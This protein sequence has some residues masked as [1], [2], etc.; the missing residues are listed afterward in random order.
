MLVRE[1]G[2][3]VGTIGGGCTE[4]S[5]WALAREAIAADAPLRERFKLSPKQAGE[6][7]LAAARAEVE[8]LQTEFVRLYGSGEANAGIR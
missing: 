1:D 7:G 4:A 6:E 2:T 5:V 8:R 3:T